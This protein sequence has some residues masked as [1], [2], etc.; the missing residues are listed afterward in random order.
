MA[1]SS[2][3]LMSAIA[4]MTMTPTPMDTAIPAVKFPGCCTLPIACRTT[5]ERGRETFVRK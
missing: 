3:V 5:K 4:T 2:E 1:K